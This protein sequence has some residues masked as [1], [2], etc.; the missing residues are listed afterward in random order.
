MALK[1]FPSTHSD[2][3][4]QVAAGFRRDHQSRSRRRVLSK[5]KKRPA[6]ETT[7]VVDGAPHRRRP[8]AEIS[9]DRFQTPKARRRREVTAIEY[10]PNRSARIALIKYTDGEMSYILAPDGLSVGAKVCAGDECRARSRQCASAQ[11]IP[12]GTNIHNI[13]IDSGPRRPDRPQRRAT[14]DVEQPRRRL[15]TGENAVRRD[16]HDSRRLLTRR[17]AR[18]AMSIT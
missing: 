14:G 5:P 13:E 17:S 16:P 12:L 4:F 8:Q 11:P 10:D 9:Q 1:K 18:S 15:R 6:A 3:A 7:T 2:A